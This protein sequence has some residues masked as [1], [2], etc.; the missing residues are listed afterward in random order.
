M[1]RR[2]IQHVI[3]ALPRNSENQR[4]GIRGIERRV[5]YGILKMTTLLVIK[6]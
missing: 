3:A 1:V 2:V 4:S 6:H 5:L